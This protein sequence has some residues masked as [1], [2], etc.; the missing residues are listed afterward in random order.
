MVINISC[1]KKCKFFKS[2]FQLVEKDADVSDAYDV[3]QEIAS[4]QIHDL[5]HVRRVEE[6]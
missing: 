4:L 2:F 1:N 5:D 3:A 6:V